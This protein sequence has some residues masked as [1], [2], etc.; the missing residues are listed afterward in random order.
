MPVLPRWRH[1]TGQ[2]VQE[3][4]RREFDDAVGARPRGLSPAP[5][6]DPVGRLVSGEHVADASDPAIFT[7]PHEEPFQ[8]E[9]RPGA[10]PQEVFQRLTLD[11]QMGTQERDPPRPADA[12]RT[13]IG[14]SIH[15][16]SRWET[17][18]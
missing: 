8:R 10:I 7:A 15:L 18:S 4:T 2:S 12:C 3:V 11:T 17:L 6:A 5:R 1:E 14:R 13:A 9:G 16:P